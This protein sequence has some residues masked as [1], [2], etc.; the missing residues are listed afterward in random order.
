MLRV[1]D[2]R[3]AVAARG[4]PPHAT[5]S[6]DLELDDDVCPWNSG[7]HRLVLE[8]G[9][10]RLEPRG[11][12]AVRLTTRGFAVLYAGAAGPA[13]LRRPGMLAGGDPDTATRSCRPPPPARHPRYSTTSDRAGAA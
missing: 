7:A 13:V 12:G 3:A 11:T 2:A 8:G 1:L 9:S 4:W 6:A 10:A 5:G